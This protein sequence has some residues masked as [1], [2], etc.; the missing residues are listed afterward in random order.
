MPDLKK[1]LILMVGLTLMM[2]G[3]AFAQAAPGGSLPT[4]S[5]YGN[6]FGTRT[7]DAYSSVLLNELFGPLF[8]SAALSEGATGNRTVFSSIIGYFNVIILVVGGL[9]F[10]YN[11]TVGVLQSA[12]EGQVLGQRWSSLWA[13]IRVLFAVGLLVPVPNYGGYNIAQLG[14]AYVVKGSTNIASEI[15]RGSVTLILSGDIPIATSETRYSPDMIRSLYD[16][17]AC[18]ALLNYQYG[19]IESNKRVAYSEIET[20]VTARISIL[21]SDEAATF[22]RYISTT[23]VTGGSRPESPGICG[24]WYTPDLPAYILRVLDENGPDSAAATSIMDRF[25]AGHRDIMLYVQNEVN[26]LVTGSGSAAPI[27]QDVFDSAILEPATFTDD[28]RRISQEANRRMNVLAEELRGIAAGGSGHGSLRQNLLDRISGGCTTL[29][30]GGNN[31]NAQPGQC[32]GEGWIGAGAYYT[33]LA[34]VNAEI[35]SLTTAQSSVNGPTYMS[36]LGMDQDDFVDYAGGGGIFWGRNSRGEQLPSEEE[37]QRILSRY[38]ELYSRSSY[39]LAALGFNMSTSDIIDANADA[40]A[41][42]EGFISQIGRWISSGIQTAQA[43]MLS[44]FDPSNAVGKDPMIGLIS[45]GGMLIMFGITL[46]G[47]SAFS[48]TVAIIAVPFFS[49]ILAAG[50]TL[51]FVLPLMPFFYWVLGVTGYFLLIVEAIV[52]VNLWALA[53]MRMDG[54][55]ISGMAGQKG[56]LMLLALLMTPVLMVF[57]F[58]IGMAIFRITSTLISSGMFYAVSGISGGANPLVALIGII[59]FSI[60]IVSAYIFLLERS[61]SLISEFPSRVMQWM[62]E[63]INIGGGEDRI[64]AAAGAAA[65]ATNS[66][67]NQ[68]EKP[69]KMRDKADGTMA[70]SSAQNGT[71]AAARWIGS[72]MGSAY[73]AKQVSSSGAPPRTPP[74]SSP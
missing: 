36:I 53:H 34:R 59:A 9:M 41:S 50:A 3:Q 19:A 7:G 28:L 1:L 65:V 68:M 10:F 12:H 30:G 21:N 15:W 13:P 43:G 52:A 32:Y 22:P 51:S 35:N 23:Y 70:P 42:T 4:P 16:N 49:V 37:A 18:M 25:A 14:V 74:S 26:G 8:P 61:F 58:L 5:D 72:R 11:V 6:L 56:W 69:F 17:A 71:L 45:T 48:T 31:S 29:A 47:I 38:S 64:R 55:G 60:M 44:F 57:G 40:G 66:L 2:V 46:L 24:S 39:P 54:D 33:T 62:G 20:P 63:N 67:G 27:R 73:S